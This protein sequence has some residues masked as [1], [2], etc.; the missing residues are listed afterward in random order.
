MNSALRNQQ[1][2]ASAQA[3][4]DNALPEDDLDFLDCDEGVEWQKEAAEELAGGNE[5]HHSLE[6][7]P[8]FQHDLIQKLLG[9]EEGQE[10]MEWLLACLL[11]DLISGGDDNALRRDV[12]ETDIKKWA[13]GVAEQMVAPYAQAHIEARM[14][15]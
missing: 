4:Y 2:M 5:M 15:S 8:V 14:E 9:S 13:L 3:A 1:A 12:C 7:V 6:G 10:K 11:D